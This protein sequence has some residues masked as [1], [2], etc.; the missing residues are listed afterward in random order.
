MMLFNKVILCVALICTFGESTLGQVVVDSVT[1]QGQALVTNNA[2]ASFTDSFLVNDFDASDAVQANAFFSEP[3]PEFHSSS[4]RVEAS[5][6][7]N[8]FEV[9][10]SGSADI[11]FNIEE[12]NF[13]NE[14][15]ANGSGSATID[16]TLDSP[17]LF[18]LSSEDNSNTNSSSTI[19]LTR[20]SDDRLIDPFN[21]NS[22]LPGSY[23]FS[24][25]IELTVSSFG[26]A[27]FFESPP[28]FFGFVADSVAATPR[29]SLTAVPE[30]S[31]AV[32]SALIACWGVLQRR[33]R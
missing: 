1:L 30:P 5:R 13:S 8:T 23:R 9:F 21:E 15:S 19:S 31:T 6:L 33:R 28:S 27:G 17:H 32:L 14:I 18:T 20:L 4:I 12:D 2:G 10:A 16:F 29:L 11:N 24:A 7:G 25:A 22:L 26:N 3:L